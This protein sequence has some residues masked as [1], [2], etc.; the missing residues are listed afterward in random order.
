MPIFGEKLK[1]L[2][3][4]SGLTGIAFAESINVPYQT[5]MGYENK[6]IEPN[7]STLKKIANALHAS[8]DD[9]LDYQPDKL[10]HLINRLGDNFKCIES[11]KP[12]MVTLIYKAAGKDQKKIEYSKEELTA[13]L[14]SICKQADKITE[15]TTK[16][17]IEQN[18]LLQVFR[19]PLSIN[20]SID[21][22][23]IVK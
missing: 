2:R 14:E 20:L 21:T 3:I 22:E 4:A 19:E 15:S 6:G 10:T 11:S 23:R 17:I 18:V 13:M 1:Q 7:Y 12:G 5:Y 9:L 8:I 16:G